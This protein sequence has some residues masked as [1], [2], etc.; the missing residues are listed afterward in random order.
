MMNV[1]HVLIP[2]TNDSM[3]LINL[4]TYLLFDKHEWNGGGLLWSMMSVRVV[5][6]QR[7][8]GEQVGQNNNNNISSWKH[9]KVWPY[10]T[11]SLSPED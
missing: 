1:L 2:E 9:L 8:Y 3:L 10:N 11:N 4:L 6:K 5:W 7:N